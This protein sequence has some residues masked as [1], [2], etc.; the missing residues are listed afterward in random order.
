MQFLIDHGIDM[1]IRDFRWGSTAEGW[2][3]YF[4][5]E[6]MAQWRAM[7]NN[8]GSRHRIEARDQ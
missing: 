1:T 2:A 5:D 8:G 6:K 7:R 4:G 3:S